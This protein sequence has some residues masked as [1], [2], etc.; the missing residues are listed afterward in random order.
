MMPYQALTASA[1]ETKRVKS[2]EDIQT[3]YEVDNG[4]S[5]DEV[6]LPSSLS[7]VMETVTS[8]DQEPDAEPERFE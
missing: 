7:V 6:G 8:S 2:V 3:K 1:A 5:L 4:T